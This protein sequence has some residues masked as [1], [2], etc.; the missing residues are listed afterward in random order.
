MKLPIYMDYHA[1]TP[2][3]PRVLEAMMPYLTSQ[4]G[5]AA[6]KHHP[7][8]W[9]AEKA[10]EQAR[11][12]IAQLIGSQA[13][14]IIFTSGATEANNLALKGIADVYKERGHHIITQA[15]EHKCVMDACKFLEKHGCKV[16]YLPVD[17][18]G[19]IQILDLEAAITDKTILISIMHANNEIG[20]VQPIAEIGKIAK[21]KGILFHV[22]A[23]QSAGKIPIDVHKMGV[24]LLSISAH[25]LYG[26]KGVGILY[27][28]SQHPHVR[29]TPQMHGGG[30]ERGFRSGTLNVPAIVGFGKAAE[31]A[32]KEMEEESAKIRELRD[33]LYMGLFK[34]LEGGVQ[35]NG[36]PSER[37]SN[38]LNLSFSD[39]EADSLITEINAE[40]AI[41]TGSACSSQVVEPSHALKALGLSPQRLQSSVRFGLGRFTTQQE[42]DYVINR[43]V[44]AVEKIKKHSP[45][46]SFKL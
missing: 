19:Q 26:P 8:G 27:I 14:E 6:S 33:R 17:H 29:L 24:D 41:S 44:K 46:K 34:S 37:L 25:K 3:D 31:I 22:D 45:I 4:F 12:H 23:A 30:H 20:T 21:H 16:T 28:R 7:F 5:N 13:K 43:V 2:L 18:Y 35:L 38:N 32:M 15:T 1:T 36:H 9:D 42:V 11:I 39:V 10:V 40:I